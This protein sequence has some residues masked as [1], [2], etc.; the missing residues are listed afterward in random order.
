MTD[1][2]TIT[3]SGGKKFDDYKIALALIPVIALIEE[4]K[5]FSEG[6]AKYGT[7]NYMQG[8]SA[9]RLLSAA[10]RHILQFMAGQDIDPETGINNLGGA[11]ACLGMLLQLAHVGRLDDDRYKLELPELTYTPTTRRVGLSVPE[12]AQPTPT[13]VMEAPKKLSLEVGKSY[14][15]RDGQVARIVESKPDYTYDGVAYPFA[16]YIPGN[17]GS[18]RYTESGAW[19][20]SVQ[21]KN[22]LLEE[23]PAS[24]AAGVAALTGG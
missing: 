15:R 7:W 16:G 11:R 4:A 12:V 14:R 21:T 24:D 18:Y 5:A 20:A 23:V 10:Q 6:Q 19:L 13:Y 2:N 8:M 17:P 9:T 3:K 22:D 1:S